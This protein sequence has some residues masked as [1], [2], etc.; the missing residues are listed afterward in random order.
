MLKMSKKFREEVFDW[1][2]SGEYLANR[3]ND[4]INEQ[5]PYLTPLSVN[6]VKRYFIQQ[7]R[8]YNSD[9]NNLE[10]VVRFLMNNP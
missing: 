1:L 9:D 2:P 6:E 5:E 8:L 4:T 3:A 7:L 10:E